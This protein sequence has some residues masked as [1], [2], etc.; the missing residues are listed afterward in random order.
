MIDP[1]TSSSVYNTTSGAYTSEGYNL[2]FSD[3]FN[4]ADRKFGDG[5]DERWT[6]INSYNFNTGDFE[7]YVPDAI[8][9]KVM[10]LYRLAHGH[11]TSMVCRT[12]S[13]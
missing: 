1:D 3:E 12:A 5:N 10:I 2:V 4:T 7:A 9:T 11:L 6:A 13:L 8:T